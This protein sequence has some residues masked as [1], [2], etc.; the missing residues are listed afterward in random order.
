MA[1]SIRMG[2]MSRRVRTC[3]LLEANRCAVAA[4]NPVFAD[5]RDIVTITGLTRTDVFNLLKAGTLR[6]VKHGR[7]N[8]IRVS[9]AMSYVES[10]PVSRSIGGAA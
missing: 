9:E 10:L 1:G 4:V 3:G 8:L 5:I 6:S 7:R 2:A